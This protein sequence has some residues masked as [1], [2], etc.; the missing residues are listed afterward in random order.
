V[1]QL[2]D[3][4]ANDNT[5]ILILLSAYAPHAR[6][7]EFRFQTERFRDFALSFR[8]R[9]QSAFEIFMA[10]GTLA[11]AAPPFPAA[12]PIALQAEF[13]SYR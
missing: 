6:T 8:D 11:S 7:S 10:G 13:A 1:K 12:L 3:E 5:A 2:L 9:W 4:L